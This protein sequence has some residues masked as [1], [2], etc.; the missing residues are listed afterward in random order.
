MTLEGF[1]KN[2]CRGTSSALFPCVSGS[3]TRIFSDVH[4]GDRASRVVALEQLRP[5]LL[6]AD[7]VLFNGDTIDT[8]H[9]P[10]PAHTAACRAALS[11][12]VHAS[13]APLT[14]LTGN[15]DPDISSQHLLEFA[16]GAILVVHGDVLFDDIV[17]WG[18]EVR[19]IRAHIAAH[20]KQAGHTSLHQL[21][22][23]ERLHLWRR[24]SGVLPQRHQAERNPLKFAVKLVFE[25][26]WPPTRYLEI[27]R[28][29][30]QEPALATR[31]LE[32]HR[33]RARFALLGH[34]HR[35]TIRQLPGGPVVI[36][37]GSFTAPFGG[38]VVDIG[39]GKLI[40]RKVVY[41]AREFHPD[42]VVAEFSI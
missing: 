33:P 37:T 40:V 36:N 6:G 2:R 28:A 38:Y 21:T 19:M 41:R 25:N 23:E 20:V 13:P 7:T 18:H 39:R 26:L 10:N 24:I 12:F 3:I 8:R 34:T 11:E 16:D 9:G 27:F 5:M 15:H 22:F 14:F 29:W 42:A 35:P 17:P 32:T 4:Y 1:R 30:H 31:F